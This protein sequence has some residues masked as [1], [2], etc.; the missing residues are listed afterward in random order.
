VSFPPIIFPGT[1]LPSLEPV[2]GEGVNSFFLMLNNVA[3]SDALTISLGS[4][5]PFEPFPADPPN[6]NRP[7][8][9]VLLPS[10]LL[11][12]FLALC[13]Y[14][15]R[16]PPIDESRSPRCSAPSPTCPGFLRLSRSVISPHLPLALLP[17]PLTSS[18]PFSTLLSTIP[19]PLIPPLLPLLLYPSPSP[20]PP[21]SLTSLLSLTTPP[22][23]TPSSP[24]P[25]QHYPPSPP[26][27]ISPPT[28]V[29]FEPGI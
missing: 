21:Y 19:L 22:P 2:Y 17:P 28:S 3:I 29:S 26:R 18:S 5:F 16:P 8:Q 13:I 20:T 7:L 27:L 4:S 10:F 1:A 14:S 24:P 9:A 15:P 23:P 12:F 25:P 6:V 11:V